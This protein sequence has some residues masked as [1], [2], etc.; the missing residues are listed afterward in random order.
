MSN[1]NIKQPV[2]PLSDLPFLSER[3]TKDKAD[4]I[5][6]TQV[7]LPKKKMRSGFDNPIYDDAVWM[8]RVPNK[9]IDILTGVIQ[10]V[11]ERINYKR[12]F[13]LFQTLDYIDTRRV[14]AVTELGERQAQNYVQICRIALPHLIRFFK[15]HDLDP[16]KQI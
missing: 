10:S 15:T 6:A 1:L 5:R 2:K 7:V 8:T 16:Y 11:G 9:V 14:M 13:N 4:R 12:I 3:L